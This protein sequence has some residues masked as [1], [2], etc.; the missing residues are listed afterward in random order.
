MIERRCRDLWERTKVPILRLVFRDS[1][2]LITGGTG[3]WGTALTK[4][5]LEQ[6]SPRQLRIYSRSEAAQVLLR[7]QLN[8]DRRVRFVIGD[9]R[10]P[11]RLTQAAQGVDTIFHLAALKHVPVCEE[12]P[13]EA[14]KTNVLGTQYVIDA[15]LACGVKRVIDVSSDKAASPLNLYGTTK[16]IGEKLIVS[17]N[18]LSETTSFI[19]VRA[20]NVLGTAGSVVPLFRSQVL[21]RN[22]VTVT[23]PEMTRFFL[24]VRDVIGMILEVPQQAVGGEIFILEMPAMR[25]GD[26]A[27]VM[28]RQLGNETTTTTVIGK[29]PGEKTHE[30]LVSAD[31]SE[32]TYRLGRFMV[33]LPMIHIPR[34]EE[35]YDRRALERVGFVDFSSAMARRLDLSEIE[36]MLR[37]ERWLDRSPLPSDTAVPFEALASPFSTEGWGPQP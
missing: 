34:V 7:R 11:E 14:V 2:I 6:W 8:D 27:E 19:C 36:A 3:S 23:D 29:R 12:N 22:M 26:L 4:L 17:A 37:R 21:H 31:E 16:S 13:F 5:L 20:G 10:D 25:I 28:A 18:N 30:I 24:N 15:A 1:T 33:L 32:R 35:R 9:V